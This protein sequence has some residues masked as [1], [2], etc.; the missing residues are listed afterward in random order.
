MSQRSAL[1][2]GHVTHHRLTPKRHS[3][4]N[5]VYWLL[6]DLTELEALN[7]RLR[8]FSYNQTNLA[9]FFN[10]DHGDGSDVPLHEQ[11]RGQLTT[12][13]LEARSLTIQ[14]LCMPRVVGYDFNPLSVYFCSTQQGDMVAVIYQVTSTF[15]GRHSYVIPI[16]LPALSGKPPTIQQPQ[17]SASQIVHQECAKEFYVSPFMDLDMSYRFRTAAP[18]DTVSVSVQARKSDAAVI[19]T[20]LHGKRQDLSDRNL[21][22]LAA[23]HPVLPMK[24]MAAIHWNAL[25]LW[26][27]GFEINPSKPSTATTVTIVG[28]PQLTHS[29]PARSQPLSAIGSQSIFRSTNE[30][31]RNA[32]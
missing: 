4:R 3:L 22:R 30:A 25:K 18:S 29:S 5:R 27:R 20:A 26:W 32:N 16:P 28:Q 10:R 9:S 19:N 23:T 17:G 15:G 12:A 11:V 8:W 31:S 14:L 24:V 1:Y 21:L 7:S 2:V 6:L 13:G